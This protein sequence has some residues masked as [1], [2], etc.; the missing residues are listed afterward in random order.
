MLERDDPTSDAIGAGLEPDPLQPPGDIPDHE[1]E[2]LPPGDSSSWVWGRSW[3]RGGPG[4]WVWTGGRW[5]LGTVQLRINMADGGVAVFVFLSVD[6]DHDLPGAARLWRW[7]PA[8][9]RVAWPPRLPGLER[10]YR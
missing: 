6:V 9:I 3:V 4:V 1:P 7:D 8:V 5:R 10:R 2:E